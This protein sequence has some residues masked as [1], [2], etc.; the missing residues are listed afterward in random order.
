MTSIT[1]RLLTADRDLIKPYRKDFILPMFRRAMDAVRKQSRQES[2][3]KKQGPSVCILLE[4]IDFLKKGANYRQD[5]GSHTP[6]TTTSFSISEE[7]RAT[8]SG[9]SES[10]GVPPSAILREFAVAVALKCRDGYL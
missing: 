8:L 4:T 2:F 5:Y 10:L 7:D 3:S 6:T 1:M 9:I